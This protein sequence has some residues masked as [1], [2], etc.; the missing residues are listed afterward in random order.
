MMDMSE[1]GYF[2]NVRMTPERHAV[3]TQMAIDDEGL[4]ARAYRCLLQLADG[5]QPSRNDVA[6]MTDGVESPPLA[7][8]GLSGHC[9]LT[10]FGRLCAYAADQG[11]AE[12]VMALTT[13][14]EWLLTKAQS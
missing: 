12:A 1:S 7:H 13:R 3:W 5:D 14:L 8:I 11:D 9:E 4:G 10:V 2:T 6:W